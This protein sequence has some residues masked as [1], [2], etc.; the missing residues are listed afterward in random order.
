ML[1]R[2]DLF[3]TDEGAPVDTWIDSCP[4]TPTWDRYQLPLRTDEQPLT[5]D[6]SLPTAAEPGIARRKM[7]VSDTR[8][9]H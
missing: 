9:D 3:D 6:T 2:S 5:S 1:P 4:P 7:L 8:S